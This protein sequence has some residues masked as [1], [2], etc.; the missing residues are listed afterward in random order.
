ML[1]NFL[2]FVYAVSFHT[3]C[4]LP[5]FCFLCAAISYIR[6]VWRL[7]HTRKQPVNNLS[8]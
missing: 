1:Q 6:S 4:Y 5:V 8:K 3:A 7:K 2:P